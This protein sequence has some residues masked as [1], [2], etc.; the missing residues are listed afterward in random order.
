[1]L[2]GIVCEY[3]PFHNGHLYQLEKTVEAG[4]DAVICVMSGNFVQRG[5]CA[6]LDKWKRAEIA[7][8]CGADVVIDLPVPWA[9]SSAENFARG[10]ISLLGN[11]GVDFISFGSECD[12]KSRLLLAAQS[13]DD[14]RVIADTRAHMSEGMS[15][16]LALYSSVKELYGSQT[17]DIISSP[18]STLAVEYIRQL[19]EF[20]G[21]DFLPVKRK[22]AD[23]D[24]SEKKEGFLSASKIRSDLLSDTTVFES[25]PECAAGFI[26]T[27]IEEGLCPCLMNSNERGILSSLRELSLSE[28]KKYISDET[29][30]ANRIYEAVQTSCSLIE[31][32]SKAKCKNYTHSRIRREV[33]SA[34][35]KIEKDIASGIPPYIRILAVSEKG[36]SLLAGAKKNSALPIV[37]RH[38]E[39]QNL[40]EESKRIYDIQ[41]STTDKFALFSSR[42][43]ESGLEQKNPMIIIR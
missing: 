9:V 17:A 11:F 18:N 19:S 7:V 32:Y 36:L 21:V 28:L 4:A 22:G 38:G 40:N 29:G 39:M 27:A 35:L 33:L 5:E 42:I 14:S 25:V 16:P 12:D 43:R 30:L 23:H 13:I 1:M 10:S 41:C 31:L 8:K 6:F 20:P 15:Y 37:T 26:T 34:Y 24:S 3:N 2:A